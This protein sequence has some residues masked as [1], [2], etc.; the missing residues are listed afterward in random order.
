M[1]ESQQHNTILDLA[2]ALKLSPATVSRALNNTS[3]VKSETKQRVIEMAEKLGYRKNTMAAGLRNNKT[4]TV[5]LI[6]PK[7]SMYFHAAVVTEIQ[8]LLHAKGYNL[9]IGQT[10]DDPL[11]EKEMADT[12][13]SSRVDALIV[14]C[15]LKTEDF[16]HFDIFSTHHIP[17]L[18]YDRV[19][20]ESYQARVIK[21]DDFNGGYLA[22]KYLAEIGC[23]QIGMICGP[24]TSN[25][26]QDRSAGFKSA[27]QFYKLPIIE[28]LFFYQSLTSANT[29]IALGKMLSSAYPPD[30]VFVTS[31]KN[32]MTV[33]TYARDHDIAIPEQLRV[34]GYSNDPLTAMMTPS[35]TTIEQFPQ[36]FGIRVVE[37][38][39]EMLKENEVVVDTTALI[40][41]VELIKRKSA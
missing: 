5:G 6:L 29:E 18:F 15:T 20:P 35:I 3:Y 22:G 24:L 11:L 9:I 30:A 1:K 2:A 33:I 32:A 41:P 39:M 4:N 38:L 23:K 28:E 12:F 27:M 21:G 40:I 34:I 19:P 13:F 36:L 25:L 26:Y 31:D 16:S 14:A 17:I 7:I 10:N 8:N 37:T